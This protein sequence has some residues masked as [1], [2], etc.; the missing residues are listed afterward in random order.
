MDC[1]VSLEGA[2]ASQKDL[3]KGLQSVFDS[4]VRQFIGSVVDSQVGERAVSRMRRIL[5]ATLD[6][7]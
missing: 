7:G 1:W 4:R 3:A 2:S 5:T 6:K